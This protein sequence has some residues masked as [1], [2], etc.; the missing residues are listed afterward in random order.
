LVE[1]F[2]GE[3]GSVKGFSMAIYSGFPTIE[4]AR[5]ISGYVLP[6]NDLSGIYHVS[7]EPVS[8]FELLRLVAERYGK[9]IDIER[10]DGFALNRSLL[11]GPFRSRTGYRPPQWPEMVETMHRDFEDNRV[12]YGPVKQAVR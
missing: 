10:Y 5:I 11:S 12:Q 6:R 4:M 2:L 1:W 8:K 7:S 3:T 9:N